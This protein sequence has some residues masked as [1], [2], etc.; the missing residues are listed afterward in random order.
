MS[1]KAFCLIFLKVDEVFPDEKVCSLKTMKHGW[2]WREDPH[3]RAAGSQGARSY[4]Q[5]CS[6][7]AG[8]AFLSCYALCIWSLILLIILN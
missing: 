3:K 2:V 5:H 6:P 7:A 1:N 4:S 8:G